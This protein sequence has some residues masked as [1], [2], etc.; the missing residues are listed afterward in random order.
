MEDVW[1]TFCYQSHCLVICVNCRLNYGIGF[2][3]WVAGL[4]S[5]GLE[6][7]P[8]LAIELTPGG[9]DLACHHSE[10]SEMITSV[11]VMEGTASAAQMRHQKIDATSSHRLHTIAG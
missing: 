6:F 11:P 10:V 7:E 5:S 3:V 9:V 2:T 1:I 8:L 4:R